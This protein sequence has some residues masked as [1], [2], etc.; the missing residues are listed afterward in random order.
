MLL[1][2]NSEIK[3]L[4]TYYDRNNSQILV[5]YGEQNV[6]KTA[7][8]KEFMQDKPNFY[9][10]AEP[11]CEREQRYKMAQWL[12]KKGIR[13]LKYPEFSEVFSTFN[14]E[15]SQKKVIVFDEFQNI[16]KSCPTFME[17][18]ISFVHNSWNNQEYLVILV[19]SSVSFVENQMVQKIGEAAFELSGFLKLK[20]LTF[21]NLKEYFPHYSTEE[22]AYIWAILGGFPGLWKCFDEK[23]SLKE[24]I[25]KNILLPNSY[26]YNYGEKLISSELRETAVYSTILS[27]LSDGRNKLLEICEHTEFVRSKVSVYLKNLM[28]LEL[29]K[30][31]FSVETEGNDFVQKG[32]YDINNHFLDFYFTFMFKYSSELQELSAQ[33]F[34]KTI[35]FPSLKTFAGKY[36][37]EICREYLEIQ[38]EKNKLPIYVENFGTWVGKPGTIDIVGLSENNESLLAL[39]LFDKPILSYDDYEWMLYCAKKAKLSTDNIYLFTVGR[40]DEKLSLEGKIRN[41][42]KL[43]LLDNMF[44]N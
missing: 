42:M 17:Q 16:I 41:N 43:L 20:E 9:Y 26:L 37:S 23:L 13:T 1:G 32:I 27:A 44:I 24:N 6:G 39:C 33:E 38:N 12:A 36:F 25:I 18:L 31:V 15:H 29:V 11:V 28:E 4:N 21:T 40:F 5:L 14:H 8:I 35:V 34:Y 2:R 19:S 10:C 3:S 30:K 22:C 7:L